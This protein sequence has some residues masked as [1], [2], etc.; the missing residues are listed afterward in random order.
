MQQDTIH[1]MLGIGKELNIQFVLGYD[2]LEF[3]ASLDAIATG[4]GR[5]R[6]AAHRLR[7]DIDE[8][9][10][11]FV[12]LGNPEAARQDHRRTVT[13]HVDPASDERTDRHGG[14][15]AHR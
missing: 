9:P 3:G 13:D 6:A 5:P 12:D 7:V 10:Q 8:V 2:P 1:P 14:P 15:F 11:A 4:E